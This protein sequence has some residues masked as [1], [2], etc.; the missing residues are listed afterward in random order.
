L[1]AQLNG[2]LTLAGFELRFAAT[3]PDAPNRW[4]FECFSKP[5]HSIP[6][7]NLI[8]S[9]ADVLRFPRLPECP[10]FS[11]S[12]IALSIATDEPRM[13]L[14]A[15]AVSEQPWTIN[16]GSTPVALF[17]TKLALEYQGAQPQAN[18]HLVLHAKA[19]IAGSETDLTA[20]LGAE[21]RLATDFPDVSLSALGQAYLP[22]WPQNF[23]DITLTQGKLNLADGNLDLSSGV[24]L[25]F[26]ALAQQLGVPLPDGFN[27]FKLDRASLHLGEQGA[28]WHAL[29]T[30]SQRLRFPVSG[31]S[32]I[33]I[34]DMQLGAGRQA[35]Q[36]AGIVCA[37]TLDGAAELLPEQVR[38]S[39]ENLRCEW[40]DLDGRWH[41]TGAVKIALFG[42]T[43]GLALDLTGEGSGK[44]FVLRATE[45]VVI[46][47]IDPHCAVAVNQ[48][49]VFLE[50]AA[51][52]TNWGLNAAAAFS[53]NSRAVSITSFCSSLKSN[54][55][56]LAPSCCC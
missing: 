55:S 5:G 47:I 49:A 56:D 30:S 36:D 35:G 20:T 39:F 1:S 14:T 17:D 50:Q 28:S 48:L 24:D 4:A 16:I 29:I 46:P 21:A 13:H 54:I 15:R 12:D 45:S 23:P 6:L 2:A 31:P 40:N 41:T 7:K 38:L 22:G 25:D 11:L 27:G 10:D 8:D 43:L 33:Q 37:F 26:A 19:D 42:Q 3:V 53:L 51:E 32:G 18:V 44:R 9:L 52:N 34:L